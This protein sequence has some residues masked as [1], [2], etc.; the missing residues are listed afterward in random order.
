M[1]AA[2]LAASL[3]ALTALGGLAACSHDGRS[4]RPPRPDQTLSIVTT[5]SSVA[6]VTLDTAAPQAGK[7]LT[8]TLPFA[9]GQPIDP[10]FTCKGA[11]QS[12][13]ISWANVP[14]EATELAISVIDLDSDPPGFVHWVVSGI[15]PSTT[16]LDQGTIPEG[17]PQS[18][19]DFGSVGWK[20]PC[21][22][23]GTQHT[24][25]FTLYALNNDPAIDESMTGSA[26]ISSLE[27]NQV[28]SVAVAGTFASP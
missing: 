25:L 27:D 4:L 1:R 20:G 6:P 18:K 2:R 28:A 16:G 24:Y 9:D 12:P 23:A 26:A 22:P 8:L 17:S 3:A 13:P 21:P 7:L 15:D 11:D 10:A 5:S 14:A 19:N